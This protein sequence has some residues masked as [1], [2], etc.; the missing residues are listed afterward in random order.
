[1]QCLVPRARSA[2]K[3]VAGRRIAN[4]RVASASD[5]FVVTT[6]QFET[7]RVYRKSV[8]ARGYGVFAPV[9]AILN[10]GM[11][12]VSPEY[13]LRVLRIRDRSLAD[14]HCKN[15]MA[16]NSSPRSGR[17]YLDQMI[18]QFLN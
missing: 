17:K 15:D 2:A 13:T 10:I 9:I 18:L 7:S 6:Y 12:K 5:W 16:A 3:S 11:P 1:M 14:H 8:I 4:S